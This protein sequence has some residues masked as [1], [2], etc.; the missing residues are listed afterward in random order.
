MSSKKSFVRP[1]GL[2]AHSSMSS[3][4]GTF[5]GSP[6]TV[7]EEENTMFFTLCFIM[8]SNKT[9]VPVIL[10]GLKMVEFVLVYYIACKDTLLS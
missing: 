3:V 6:Y 7:A 1:Y 4:M 2:V 8:T 5:L 10:R 9:N